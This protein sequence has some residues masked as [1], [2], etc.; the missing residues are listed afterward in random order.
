MSMSTMVFPM[1]IKEPNVHDCVPFPVLSWY[2]FHS[3]SEKSFPTTNMSGICKMPHSMLA[4]SKR[5]LPGGTK[6]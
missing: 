4:I 1:F 5:K 6:M 3:A 2:F